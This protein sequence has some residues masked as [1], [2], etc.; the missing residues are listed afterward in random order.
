MKSKILV[1]LVIF[2]WL[3]LTSLSFWVNYTHEIEEQ[4]SI[5]HQSA[6]SFF[7]QVE[8]T[9]LWNAR[10]G[11]LYVPATEKTPPNP[12]LNVPMR[13]IKINDQFTLTQINPAYMTKQ[14]SEIAL[15]KKG[16]QFHITSL[17]PLNPENSPTKSEEKLLREFELGV[18][19]KGFFIEEGEKTS[20]FYM[21]PLIAEKACL[22]CHS[23]QGYK[24]GDIRGGISVKIPYVMETHLFTLLFWHIVIGV[25]GVAGTIFSGVKLRKAYKTIER[26]A[27]Y[28]SLTGIPNRRSFMENILLEFKRS[29]RE[30]QPL[31][32][33]MCDI[34]HF[35]A[36]NDSYGH[37]NGDQCL[38]NVAQSIKSSLN[39]PGDFLARFG[40]EEFIILL[41]ATTL[42]GALTIAERI[43]ANIEKLSIPN[44]NSSPLKIVTLSLG[45]SITDASSETYET[46]VKHADLALYKAKENGRNQVQAYR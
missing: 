12:Y 10:H 38:I 1:A 4:E 43:R 9:R 5:A 45:V 25:F 23:Q 3:I 34:D 33:I 17:N 42:N 16:V 21:A 35:K 14:I 19:E 32:V 36:F 40:G 44:K 11:S 8:I 41:P 18:K 37:D 30:Q 20:Y 27:K 26:L 6:Q 46:L 28:D 24:E 2:A 31:A 39:R 7:N 13:D 15:E 29:Q 22:Q